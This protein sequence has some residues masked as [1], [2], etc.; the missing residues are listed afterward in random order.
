MLYPLI[1][2]FLFDTVSVLGVT[3][4]TTCSTATYRSTVLDTSTIISVESY[5]SIYDC[6]YTE[7]NPQPTITTQS[8]TSSTGELS[9]TTGIGINPTDTLIRIPPIDSS[10]P[11]ASVPS[12]PEPDTDDSNNSNTLTSP[13]PSAET[14]VS[15][16]SGSQSNTNLQPPSSSSSSDDPRPTSGTGSSTD[17][18]SAADAY[19]PNDSTLITTV[20]SSGSSTSESSVSGSS[21]S[22]SSNMDDSID[23]YFGTNRDTDSTCVR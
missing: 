11:T 2:L 17:S 6:S 7:V 23:E 13:E 18:D 3:L 16:V 10:G 22:T 5:L 4:G 21:D 8:G 9:T 20:T 19:P 14:G 12:T 1:I 15:D